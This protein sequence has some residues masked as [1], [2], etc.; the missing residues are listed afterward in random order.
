MTLT[1]Q[2]ARMIRISYILVNY[3]TQELTLRCLEGLYHHARMDKTEVIVVDNGSLRGPHSDAL[4]IGKNFPQAKIIPSRENIGFG[5]ACNLAAKNAKG[6]YLYF[7]NSDV[8]FCEDAGNMLA[9]FMEGM[10]NAWAAGNRVLNSDGTW[11]PSAANFP[12]LSRILAGRRIFANRLR[13]ALPKLARRLEMFLA[14]ED[15]KTP[16]KVDWCTGAS[17]MFRADAFGRLH[18]FD[19]NIFLY[20]E[21]L[22]LQKRVHDMGGEVWFTPQSTVIHHEAGSSGGQFSPNRLAGIAAGHR[23]YYLKHHGKVI[24]TIMS[25]TDFSASLFKAMLWSLVGLISHKN[26]ACEKARWHCVAVRTFYVKHYGPD[27]H[28]YI[29]CYLTWGM[30][31]PDDGSLSSRIRSVTG[32]TSIHTRI[33]GWHMLRLLESNP[34]PERVLELGFGEG[35]LLL[36]LARRHPDTDFEGWEI[37]EELIRRASAK[38]DKL[39]LKNIQFL[40]HDYGEIPLQSFF[41]LIFC[42]D[43]LEHIPDDVGLIRYFHDS[44]EPD[45]RLIVH[46]PYRGTKQFRFL[47]W[48]KNHTDP[49]HLRP[50]YTETELITLLEGGGFRNVDIRQTF[51]PF[52]EAAFELNSLAWKNHHLDRAVRLL[53][54]LPALP[55]GVLDVT[56]PI[57]HGNSLLAECAKDKS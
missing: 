26:Q 45:G 5:R 23:Y 35:E 47:P 10:P 14:E 4:V 49:G 22:E 3:Q 39:R 33:R 55:L 57:T 43:V 52:G 32:V 2:D 46:V 34:L 29:A 9:D 37:D 56:F 54:I 51:G 12:T 19:P 41:G 17:L 30:I 18:G 8:E 20:A 25:I 16:R 13:Q 1:Y 36:F 50:E 53:T 38:A 28:S 42:A 27:I 31:Q 15:L 7:V 40:R 21:E 24:G 6:K 44:L 48:F 11:Q